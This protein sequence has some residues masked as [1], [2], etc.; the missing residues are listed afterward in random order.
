MKKEENQGEPA[1][2]ET[3]LRAKATAQLQEEI[4]K[5]LEE[6]SDEEQDLE[7]MKKVKGSLNL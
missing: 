6:Q 2:V 1:Y 7:R 4:D 5:E 3:D